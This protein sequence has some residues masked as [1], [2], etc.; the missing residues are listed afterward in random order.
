MLVLVNLGA[1]YN[2]ILRIV[3]KRLSLE[4]TNL[5]YKKILSYN[6]ILGYTYSVILA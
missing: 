6:S 3:V 1:N 2:F 4:I 5:N